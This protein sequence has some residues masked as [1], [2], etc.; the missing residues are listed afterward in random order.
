M[1][2]A[3]S[4]ETLVSY[5]I[6]TRGHNPEDHDMNLQRRESLK[7]GEQIPAISVFTVVYFF[8]NCPETF[9]YTLVFPSVLR[10]QTFTIYVLLG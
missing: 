9:E 1:E 4:S 2:A 3:Q 6:S 5:H 10:S 8:I 7:T